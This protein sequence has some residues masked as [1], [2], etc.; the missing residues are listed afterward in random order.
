M[1]LHFGQMD[2]ISLIFSDHEFIYEFYPYSL[3]S[4][5]TGHLCPVLAVA[6]K[7]VKE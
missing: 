5:H 1:Q 4:V 2:S 7:S 3:R 6:G